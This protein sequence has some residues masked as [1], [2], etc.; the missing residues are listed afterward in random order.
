MDWWCL[1]Y[2]AKY[3]VW[4]ITS[5]AIFEEDNMELCKYI[6]SEEIVRM[7]RLWMLVKL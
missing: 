1:I 7:M 6:T 3:L 5:L 2:G 4:D